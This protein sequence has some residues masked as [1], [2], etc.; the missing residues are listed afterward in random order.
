MCEIDL[1]YCFEDVIS[2]PNISIAERLLTL[3]FGLCY[4]F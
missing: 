4:C 3:N 1:F 2:S